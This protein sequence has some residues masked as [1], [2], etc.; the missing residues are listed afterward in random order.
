MGYVIE[1][2][3]QSYLVLDP[4]RNRSEGKSGLKQNISLF[5]RIFH[6]TCRYAANVKKTS[7]IFFHENP[8]GSG[9]VSRMIRVNPAFE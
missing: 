1:K 8:H 4:E 3:Q 5:M 6:D 7:G 2:L 9:Q